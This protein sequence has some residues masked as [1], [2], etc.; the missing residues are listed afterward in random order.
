LPVIETNVR[1]CIAMH[2]NGA[3]TWLVV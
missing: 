3:T 1:L 2:P